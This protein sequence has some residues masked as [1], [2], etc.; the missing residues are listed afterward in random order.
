MKTLIILALLKVLKGAIVSYS[1]SL[2]QELLPF[3]IKVCCLWVALFGL[4]LIILRMI[5]VNSH[6]RIRQ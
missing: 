2:Y 4:S 6:N 3:G 1:Q 5:L